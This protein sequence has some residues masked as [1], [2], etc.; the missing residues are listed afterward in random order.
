MSSAWGVAAEILGGSGSTLSKLLVVSY[1]GY[2]GGLAFDRP[3]LSRTALAW[4]FVFGSIW[5]LFVII[6]LVRN[7]KA[8][9]RG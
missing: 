4:V 7:I 8:L 5:L 9:A 2:L 6:T 1:A 3:E